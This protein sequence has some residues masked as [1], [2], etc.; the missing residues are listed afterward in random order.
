MADSSSLPI[1]QI[2]ELLDLA[3]ERMR[4]TSYSSHTQKAYIH[5]IRRFLLS[6]EGVWEHIS[7]L[8]ARTKTSPAEQA[9]IWQY[10]FPS[11][12]LSRDPCIDQV[13]RYHLLL[14]PHNIPVPGLT[15]Y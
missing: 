6:G 13:R 5:W 12:R 11:N 2:Q 15:L 3:W 1:S 14:K 4:Q 10:V 8:H 9:W 7:A